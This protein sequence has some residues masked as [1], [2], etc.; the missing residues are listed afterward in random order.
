MR[1]DERS[2]LQS[3]RFQQ[4]KA[5]SKQPIFSR[6]IQLVLAVVIIMAFADLARAATII[7]AGAW[8]VTVDSSSL[9]GGAG[10]NLRSS[11]E[12]S[13]TVPVV[14]VSVDR[15]EL[16]GLVAAPWRVDVQRSQTNWPFTLRVRRISSG[17]N[18]SLCLLQGSTS[19][20]TAYTTIEPTA[21]A[22]FSGSGSRTGIGLQF[23]LSGVSVAVPAG[24]YTTTITYTAI[25]Q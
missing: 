15:C 1:R 2:Q 4:G 18:A 11:Y 10:S 23:E 14:S 19:G 3:A 20:G 22:F 12:S 13:A 8:L 21:K 17:V 9:M 6:P 16:I 7:V 24:I 5:M 25:D